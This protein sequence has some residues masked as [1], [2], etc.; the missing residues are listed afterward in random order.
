MHEKIL[1]KPCIT[2]IFCFIILFC[3]HL[4][5]CWNIKNKQHMVINNY[6]NNDIT[7]HMLIT[8]GGWGKTTSCHNINWNI[9]SSRNCQK[10]KQT[11]I[12]CLQFDTFCMNKHFWG[13]IW[14][15]NLSRYNYSVSPDWEKTLKGWKKAEL[16][17]H[18][19]RAYKHCLSQPFRLCLI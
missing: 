4:F 18:A 19:S 15:M 14:N 6:I 13:S 5:N 12:L 16:W 11:D 1:Y 7:F 8:N 2:N 17:S 9:K 10:L 3:Y